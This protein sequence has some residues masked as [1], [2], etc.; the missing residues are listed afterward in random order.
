MKVCDSC[1]QVHRTIHGHPACPGHILSG[2]RKGDACTHPLGLGT[3]HPGWGL[4]RFHGGLLP[5]P[6]KNAA[7]MQVEAEM[8]KFGVPIPI[9]QYDYIVTQ[10]GC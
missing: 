4:C 6:T 3:K 9:Y 8:R 7:K 5:G 2:E 10:Y 1:G